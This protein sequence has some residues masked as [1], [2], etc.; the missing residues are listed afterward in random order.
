MNSLKKIHVSAGACGNFSPTAEKIHNCCSGV[1]K[2]FRGRC[3]HGQ[4]S[5]FYDKY[6]IVSSF[7]V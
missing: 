4:N 5:Q 2:A 1:G 6:S 7:K 3:F